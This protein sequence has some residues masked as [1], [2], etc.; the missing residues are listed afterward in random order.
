MIVLGGI[1]VLAS[2]VVKLVAPEGAISDYAPPLLAITL[3][4]AFLFIARDPAST[5]A[6]S[7]A[8]TAG[9]SRENGP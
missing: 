3:V 5:E 8:S 7:P 1:Y 4:I 2:T 9:R 6:H